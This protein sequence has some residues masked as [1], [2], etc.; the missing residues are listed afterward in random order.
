MTAAE[1]IR[2]IEALTPDEQE[3]VVRYA[4][5]VGARRKLSPAELGARAQRLT[6]TDDPLEAA[7]IRE[8]MVQGFYGSG[9]N[10]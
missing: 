3:Q 2:E 8:E 10:A 7:V 1:I 4:W 6:T 5:Q 9:A